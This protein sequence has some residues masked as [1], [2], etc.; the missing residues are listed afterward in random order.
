[1]NFDNQF[2]E[3][4]NEG[5]EPSTDLKNTGF[6]GGYKPPATVF[7]WFWAKVMKAVTELQTKFGLHADSTSNPHS[8]TK[9]QVGLGNV[10]N[11]S[12]ANKPVSTATQT[13]L[14]TKA[15]LS[16]GN[17]FSGQQ[18]AESITCDDISTASGKPYISANQNNKLSMSWMDD[19]GGLPGSVP[20]I[21]GTKYNCSYE[22]S[23]TSML[24]YNPNYM[25]T[26]IDITGYCFLDTNG[27]E[28]TITEGSY[29]SGPPGYVITGIS[30]SIPT[31]SVLPSSGKIVLYK[32]GSLQWGN[33]ANKTA[34]I[35]V[36]TTNSSCKPYTEQ[37]VDFL[38]TGTNDQDVIEDAIDY[39]TNWCVGNPGGKIVLLEGTYHIDQV[40]TIVADDV[41]MEGMGSSTKILNRTGLYDSNIIT[42]RGCDRFVI[43]NCHFISN[44]STSLCNMFC[45]GDSGNPSTHFT[46][47]NNIFSIAG[48][49]AIYLGRGNFMK[50]TGNRFIA[51]ENHSGSAVTTNYSVGSYLDNLIITDNVLTNL[52]L[53]LSIGNARCTMIANNAFYNTTTNIDIRCNA[54]TVIGN[55]LYNAVTKSISLGSGS[56]YNLVIGNTIIGTDIT[57]SGTNNTK[58]ANVIATSI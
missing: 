15:N 26:D 33:P 9:A 48:G 31:T 50:I 22:L 13:A 43:K 56:Q 46:F 55:I 21:T 25:P 53:G 1:M 27:T 10:D 49:S 51:A 2:P 4:N 40:M 37:E 17:T 24:F 54:S 34:S 32:K 35:V 12:D 38:C 36:G 23:S 16:G 42:L 18:I 44:D 45:I 39:V 29:N 7:N 57:D 41:T 3:W 6:Q 14:N 30:P 11:T 47:E 58:T 20:T 19:T 5:T 8:V 52:G 28:Y